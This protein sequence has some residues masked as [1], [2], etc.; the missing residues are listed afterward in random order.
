MP[1]RVVIADDAEGV[2]SLTRELLN[3]HDD[4]T[5]VGEAIDGVEAVAAVLAF[6]P[7]VLLLD[8]SMPRMDGLQV[9]FHL[10]AQ[11][12]DTRIVVL[13]GFARDRMGPL[14]LEAGASSYLEKGASP[15]VLRRAV[16]DACGQEPQS[17]LARRAS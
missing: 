2:R 15:E 14:L 16:L 11:E 7:D 13:S 17:E 12:T 4:I 5:V 10:R 8:L 1:C 6:H 9:L 3:E